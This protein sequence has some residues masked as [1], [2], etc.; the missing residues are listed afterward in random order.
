[1]IH[2]IKTEDIYE[3]FDKDK[4]M[5]NISNYSSQPKYFD[6]ANQLVATKMKDETGCVTVEKFVGLKPKMY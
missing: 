6:N 5:V 2:E 3:D 4:E 1:M